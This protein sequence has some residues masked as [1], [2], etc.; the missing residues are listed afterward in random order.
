MKKRKRMLS[1]LLL[2][3]ASAFWGI[4]SQ[5]A[6]ENKA[7]LPMGDWNLV[8]QEEFDGEK[9]DTGK[10]SDS[11]MPHWT[12]VNQS[13]AHYDLKDGIISLNID[14]ESQGPWWKYG[15]VQ[16]VS[17]IQTG[18]RDGMHNFWSTCTITDHHRAVSNYET[19]YGY[20]EIR[21]RVPN[22]GGLHSA[23]WMIGAENREKET[24]EIDIFEICGPDV[25]SGQSRVRASVHPWRDKGLKE[26]SLDYYPRCDV[27]KEFHVYGFEWTKN[28]M[29][30]YFDGEMV[31]E[32]QQSPDYPMTTFLGIYENDAPLWSG[33][34][35][36]HS[37][38]PKRFE[39]DYFRVY[40]TNEMM[41][42]DARERKEPLPGENLAPYAIAGASQDWVWN[43]PLSNMIDNDAYS[44]M[45][46]I[47]NPVFPQY[48][49]LDWD[50]TYSFDT[51]IM[52][53]AYG[54]NQAPSNWELEVSD[55]GI[56]GWKTIASS[57]KVE[58]QGNDWHVENK[59]LK[60]PEVQGKALRIKINDANCYWNHYA[61]NEVI[62]KNGKEIPTGANIAL[63]STSE[64]D[65][66]NGGLLTDG[67][68]LSAGQSSDNPQMPFDIVFKWEDAV[69]MDEIRLFSWYSSHQAATKI[70]LDGSA[71]G[72]NWQQ[73]I[74]PT[75]I[76][77]E[78]GDKTVEGKIF[79]FTRT[80]NVKFLRL[81]VHEANL[82]WKHFAINEVEI[83]DS[84]Q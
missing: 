39:I 78:H 4:N 53:A 46:S 54:K 82:R 72:S 42:M 74:P 19:K 66:K 22:D 77:W 35:D 65:S 71:D 15:G 8:F 80:E 9:L 48:I 26:E 49:Y 23:W 59:V 76:A 10:F 81:K 60:F 27:S 17:S 47:D 34:P 12:T 13:L 36:Y 50:K 56:S 68:H 83:Y 55:D 11:Y 73:I 5:S 21:A 44:A 1:I 63:E 6:E 67:N 61:I 20:F 2:V 51:F 32:T 30:Y 45:Q 57:G 79:R 37:V 52:K 14:K 28:G 16:K 31:S 24:G 18:M 41:E 29:K 58:W 3:C 84:G 70:S 75:S 40:K 69:A 62:V 7:Y 64:W 25:K 43:R 38:Y 33:R